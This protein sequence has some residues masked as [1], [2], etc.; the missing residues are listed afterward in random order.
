MRFILVFLLLYIYTSQLTAQQIWVLANIDIVEN[1][2]TDFIK[3]SLTTTHDDILILHGNALAGQQKAILTKVRT[4]KK[5]F[6]KVYLIPGDKDWD[7]YKSKELKKL[8]DYLDQEIGGD[9]IVPENGCGNLEVKEI[10]KNLALVFLDS[11][12]Y[13][14]NWDEDKHINKGC[15]VQSREGYWDHVAGKLGKLKANQILLFTR[16][17]LKRYDTANGRNRISDHIFPLAD[18][19][20]GFY[21]PLPIVG[22]FINDT[23][24]YFQAN[25]SANS[26]LYQEYVTQLENIATKHDALT[27]I[28]SDSKLTTVEQLGHTYMININSQNHISHNATVPLEHISNE[29]SI[30]KIDVKGSV[31]TSTILDF[32]GIIEHVNI[33]SSELPLRKA[34]SNKY[35]EDISGNITRPIRKEADYTRLNPLIFGSL[36]AD[37]YLKEITVPQLDLNTKHGGLTP[38]R[39]GG[40]LQT[41]SLRFQDSLGNTYVARSLK[42]RAKRALPNG[43]NYKPFVK[44]IEH[45]FMA[46]EPVALL[47][48][49]VMDSAIQVLHIT[50]EIYHLPKQNKLGI[51]NDQIGGELVSFR[52]R[53]DGNWSQ[54][55]SYGNSKNIISSTSMIKKMEKNKAKVDAKMYLRARLLDLIQ[56]DWDRHI[57]QWRWAEDTIAGDKLNTYSPIARDK[58]QV[59]SNY[60]G[61]LMKLVRPYDHNVLQL[62]KFDH[63]LSQADIRWMYWMSSLLDNTLLHNLTAE[64][65]NE[66]TKFVKQ[67]LTTE[68]LQTAV[69]KLPLSYGEDRADILDKL[70]SRVND[71]DNTSKIF[72]S[73]LLEHGVVKCSSENDSIYI[74]LKKKSIHIKVIADHDEKNKNIKF[75]GIFN[76]ESTDRI[77]IYGLEGKDVFVVNGES[78]NI[79]LTIIGG[80]GKDTYLSKIKHPSVT[81]V[82]DQNRNEV[83]QQTKEDYREVQHKSIHDFTRFD[84]IPQHRFFMPMS[85]YDTDNGVLIGGGYTW[86]NRGFKNITTHKLSAS[87]LT[88]RQSSLLEYTLNFH[89]ELDRSG[90]YF[91]GRWSGPKR[92]IRYYGGNNSTKLGNLKYHNRSGDR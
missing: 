91:M 19:I 55:E 46:S 12:W 77:W 56:G 59:F 23:R 66:Q 54:K 1:E 85:G 21:I 58:D 4:L 79:D 69:N 22:T 63:K 74:N 20:P 37:R 42:K 36:N 52:E 15:A 8:G 82:D 62:R 27:I 17:P 48:S 11:E 72:R 16:Y 49:E 13:F 39:L 57:D 61:F 51:Y 25:S 60:D 68:I 28:T 64:Q 89:D 90:R 38:L 87:Y 84:L 18:I 53:A 3:D 65:W 43:L 70:K 33:L 26:P 30:L 45:Y 83:K 71:I 9:I 67:N 44:T 81:I 31:I 24:T 14:Q 86:I 88:Q 78:S 10:G 2:A 5:H 40:G 92:Q 7:Y 80:Y 32:E 6:K 47:A 29:P 41:R 76:S 35:E 34:A 50:P 75:D 73:E